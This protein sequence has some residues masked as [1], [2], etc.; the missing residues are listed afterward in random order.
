MRVPYEQY[1]DPD[2]WQREIDLIYKRLPIMV[3]LSI[4]IPEPG[5]FKTIEMLGMPLLVTRASDGEARVML[6]VCSHRGMK[7]TTEGCGH[8]R[9]FTCPYHRWS[10][11]LDGALKGVAEYKKFGDVDKATLG[12]TQ[13]SCHEQGGMIFAVLTPGL[14]VDFQAFLGG[15]IA[16]VEQKHFENWHFCGRR[17]IFGGNWK[18]AYD[19]YLEGYHFA[20][21]HPETIHPRTYSNIMHFEAHGPHILI[22]FPQR[23]IDQLRD[24]PRDELWKYE[25]NG[26]D[27]IR[28]FFPNISIFVAPEITQVAQLIPGPTPAENRTILYFL[29]PEPPANDEEKQATETM[30]DWLQSV[31]DR[32]DYQVGLQV[33]RGLESGAHD[34]VIFGRNE[35][36]N[37][38]FHRWLDYYLAGEADAPPPEL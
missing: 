31:V 37:Q 18:V 14:E 8:A 9:L 4:E 11:G 30:V 6:N 38:Y 5:D 1:T 17:E 25:N 13:L 20:A 32:E 16:D 22:G 36:G 26:Y 34:S 35:R 21:A 3:G 19:G 10:Y 28:T 15:M 2:V 29:K 33:Q 12:L 24:V 27:F 23:S 7:L